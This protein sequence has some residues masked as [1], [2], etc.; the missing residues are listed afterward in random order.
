MIVKG[1]QGAL[2]QLEQMPESIGKHLERVLLP[3]TSYCAAHRLPGL[4]DPDG[5]HSLG[6]GLCTVPWE[7]AG[8]KLQLLCAACHRA[9]EAQGS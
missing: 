1:P 2:S 6:P 3:E 8:D 5:G 4:K 9:C 7:V